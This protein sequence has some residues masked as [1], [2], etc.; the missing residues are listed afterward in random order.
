MEYG[1]TRPTEVVETEQMAKGSDLHL[2]RELSSEEYVDVKVESDEDIFAIKAL[3]LYSHMKNLSTLKM[4]RE[5]PIFGWIGKLFLMGKIDELRYDDQSKTI[6]ICEFKTR[7]KPFLPGA[8]QQKTHKLQLMIY[9]YLLTNF[10]ETDP[11]V[12]AKM[13]KINASK[14]LGKDVQKHCP[15]KVKTIHDLLLLI[16]QLPKVEISKLIIEYS[17][18]DK[19]EVFA[20]TEEKY[21]EKWLLDNVKCFEEYWFGSRFAQG[22]DI[23]EA[24][25]CSMCSFAD[26][27]EWRIAKAKELNRNT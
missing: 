27:C 24:W 6:H 18:Q 13:M 4:S 3:N 11:Q 5:V 19:D 21:D 2:A 1:F 22:V 23:E 7:M 25:K 12:L 16:K 26:N 20:T 14:A 9:Q 15:S 10:Q 8:A 17:C